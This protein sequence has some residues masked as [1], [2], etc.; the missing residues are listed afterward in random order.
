VA[1]SLP[2]AACTM[3]GVNALSGSVQP[4]PA[5]NAGQSAYP[6]PDSLPPLQFTADDWS[7]V[8]RRKLV[9]ACDAR[10][11]A[12][13]ADAA[14]VT[15]AREIL[16]Q[17]GAATGHKEEAQAHAE[18]G[19]KVEASI[20]VTT[21]VQSFE[22]GAFDCAPPRASLTVNGASVPFD[23]AYASTAHPGA[24][25]K[26]LELMITAVSLKSGTLASIVV[27]PA[28]KTATFTM[29]DLARYLTEPRPEPIV[30]SPTG[31]AGGIF[32]EQDYFF[33]ATAAGK[34]GVYVMSKPSG[35]GNP[36]NLAVGRFAM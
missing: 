28:S 1:V 17:W 2:I 27:K 20:T 3:T 7:T 15:R 30:Y 5:T 33:K 23:L 4:L 35:N 8:E 12:P 25:P 16:E 19:G 24:D 11:P 9:V 21:P 13:L 26:A 34:P 31:A 36:S 6:P 14:S 18:A 22:T 10:G 32:V 29:T